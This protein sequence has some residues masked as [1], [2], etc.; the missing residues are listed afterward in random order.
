MSYI[1]ILHIDLFIIRKIDKTFGS[2]IEYMPINSYKLN[3]SL[4]LR[5]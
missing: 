5:H 4:K 2:D 3:S 1:H